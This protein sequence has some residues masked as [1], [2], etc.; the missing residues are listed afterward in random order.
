M[1]ISGVAPGKG[2]DRAAAT[3][4]VRPFRERPADVARR[5]VLGT[6][7]SLKWPR[8]LGVPGTLSVLAA[9][10]LGL[11]P[12]AGALPDPERAAPYTKGLVGVCTDLS[13]AT[14]LDA[15][16][17]GLF[18]FCHIG[19]VK[20]WAPP[21]RMVLRFENFHIEKNLRRR[22]RN[23][24]FDVTFDQDFR[25]VME[26]CAEPRP[27]RPHLTWITPRIMDAFAALHAAGHAHS[28]EVWDKEGNLAGGLYGL[29]VGGAFFTESQ[30]VRKRDAS[31]VGF[32]TLNCH[33]QAWGFALN[34]GKHA[35]P[36]LA[37]LGFQLM[38]RA[39]F[40][41]LLA[42]NSAPCGPSGRWQVD[43]SLDVGNWDP[44]AGPAPTI[45]S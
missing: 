11:G 33:L 8:V 22:L 38:P 21:Q 43:E 12:K 3:P 10:M 27:G 41:A 26:G 19:P 32:A 9:H 37:H 30:F 45:A 18:P 34:D 16:G 39:E 36:N 1:S 14:L 17:R 42:A 28:V 40:T 7:W 31:K 24:H 44:K 29:A 35:T 15:Y 13:V 5:W 23:N 6:A 25:A 2:E 4:P 20:W